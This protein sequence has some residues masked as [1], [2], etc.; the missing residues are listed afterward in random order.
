LSHSHRRELNKYLGIEE[1]EAAGAKSD[2][3][4]DVFSER[5]TK[6]QEKFN[7]QKRKAMAYWL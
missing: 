5:L 7:D 2:K 3:I 1:P 4:S 6:E